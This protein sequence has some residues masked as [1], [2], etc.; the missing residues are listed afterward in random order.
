MI[1]K[2]KLIAL[3]F[4]KEFEEKDIEKIQSIG[5]IANYRD[6]DVLFDYDNEIN[7]LFILV[8]GEVRF[9]VPVG[10]GELEIHRVDKGDVF[11]LSS[12]LPSDYRTT[13][14]AVASGEVE[15]IEIDIGKLERAFEKEPGFRYRF[16]FNLL[17]LFILKKDRGNILLLNS[18]LNLPPVKKYVSFTS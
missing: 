8:R 6:G 11:G 12:I 7:V 13:F 2:D 17:R 14:K 15:V 9:V 18:V 3:S 10:E 1:Q 4:V 16:Y 5:R